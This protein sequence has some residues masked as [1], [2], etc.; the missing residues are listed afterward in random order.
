LSSGHGTAAQQDKRTTVRVK[1]A[2]G[3]RVAVGEFE[4]V[5]KP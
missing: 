1:S 3:E 4:V 2:S 5:A